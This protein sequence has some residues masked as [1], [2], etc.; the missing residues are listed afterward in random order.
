MISSTDENKIRFASGVRPDRE[1][2]VDQSS[3]TKRCHGATRK[4]RVARDRRE[5]GPTIVPCESR[6]EFA[7][8]M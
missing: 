7:Q 1:P 4:P 5:A 8:S 2:M 3:Q 6:R